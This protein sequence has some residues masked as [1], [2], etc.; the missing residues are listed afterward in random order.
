M[1]ERAFELQPANAQV[2]QPTSSLTS[3]DVEVE[4]LSEEEE[5]DNDER[6]IIHSRPIH[7]ADLIKGQQEDDS[8][9]PLFQEARQGSQQLQPSRMTFSMQWT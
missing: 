2:D 1:R 3:V 4:R 6:V 8:L 5:S 9:K 7:R